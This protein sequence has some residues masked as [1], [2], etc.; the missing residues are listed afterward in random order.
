MAPTI[1]IRFLGIIV[2]NPNLDAIQETKI[3]LQNYDAEFGKAVG[4]VVTVQTKSGSN[5][6]HGEGFWFRRT[7]ATAARDP[8]TQYAP[9]PV[10][11]K[12]I[13]SDKWQQFGGTIG[14]PI[15]KNKLFFFGDY[16]GTRETNGTTNLLTVPTAEVQKTCNPATLDRLLRFEPVSGRRTGSGSGGWHNAGTYLGGQVYKPV[17]G[18]GGLDRVAYANNQIPIGD[19]SPQAAAI[20]ALFPAPTNSQVFNNFVASGSGSFKQ[21]SF[22][23]RIDFTAAPTVQVFGRFSLDYFNVA[24][25]RLLRCARGRWVWT[26]RLIGKFD[27]PQLQLG[28]RRNEDVQFHRCWRISA[29]DIS[30]TIPSRRNPM[31]EQLR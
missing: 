18:D 3:D 31:S 24:G 26:R 9:N 25:Q 27:H 1:R 29:S 11:G 2:V 22:D 23:T 28:L 30:N 5:D 17:P 14:G 16:Q 7:D 8:F 19:I 4:G 15:I 12:F 20:L 6:F 13:P 21:D 10:T